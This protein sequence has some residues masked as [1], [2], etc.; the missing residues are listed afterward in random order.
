MS[1]LPLLFHCNL[2]FIMS[3]DSHKNSLKWIF[4]FSLLHGEVIKVV[5]RHSEVYL[6]F[7]RILWSFVLDNIPI[8]QNIYQKHS[9]CWCVYM[10]VCIWVRDR[11]EDREKGR[12]RPRLGEKTIQFQLI[13]QIWIQTSDPF[14]DIEVFWFVWTENERRWPIKKSQLLQMTKQRKCSVL[15]GDQFCCQ[16]QEWDLVGW[17]A[18]GWNSCLT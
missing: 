10:H 12:R 6:Q 13:F 4:F 8:S 2:L 5:K 17:R 18:L 1:V 7:K 15:L 3:F 11:K 14:D 16:T 9:V